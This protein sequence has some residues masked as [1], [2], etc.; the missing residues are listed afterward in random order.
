MHAIG[1]NLP[2]IPVFPWYLAQTQ[3][4]RGPSYTTWHT[5]ISISEMQGHCWRGH[6]CCHRT[7]T[8]GKAAAPASGSTNSPERS[9]L[10]TGWSK[11]DWSQWGVSP[12][13]LLPQPKCNQLTSKVYSQIKS[14]LFFY[15]SFF[16]LFKKECYSWYMT[17]GP[18]VQNLLK[19]KSFTLH[20]SAFL[21][22]LNGLQ[23]P[24]I[25]TH[26]CYQRYFYLI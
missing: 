23:I 12:L 1:L 25:N 6:V 4:N 17:L 18:T 21:I 11:V 15:S 3:T 26:L 13:K 19:F 5:G 16:F 9:R 2:C 14:M 10:L 20:S 7:T 24:H 22:F 8:G